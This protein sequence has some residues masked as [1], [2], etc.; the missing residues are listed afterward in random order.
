MEEIVKT[1]LHYKMKYPDALL[2]IGFENYYYAFNS[3]AFTLQCFTGGVITSEVINNS[4]YFYTAKPRC[5]W[6]R[7]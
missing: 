5:Q 4:L 1:Y 2:L 3:S 7:P 6:R